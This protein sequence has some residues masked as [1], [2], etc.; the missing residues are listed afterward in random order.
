V[1][2][3]F[4]EGRGLIGRI[5]DELVVKLQHGGMQLRHDDVFVVSLVADQRAL[6]AVRSVRIVEPGQIPS[7]CRLVEF[8]ERPPEPELLP[9]VHVRLVVGSPPVDRIEVQPRRAKVD[10][11]H[12]IVLLLKAGGR[13]ERDVVIDELTEIRVSHR[14]ARVFLVVLDP[15]FGI[16]RRGGRQQGVLFADFGLRRHVAGGAERHQCLD[17]PHRHRQRPK[18][19]AESPFEQRRPRDELIATHAAT[20]RRRISFPQFGNVV[21]HDVSSAKKIVGLVVILRSDIRASSR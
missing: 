10:Q 4:L 6:G 17:R 1:L 13:I 2:L 8:K 15:F 9:V 3:D 14:D 7:L 21:G 16:L 20:V 11:G 18:H 19:P 5:V 12:R